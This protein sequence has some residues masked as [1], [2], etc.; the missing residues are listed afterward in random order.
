M[1]LINKSLSQVAKQL[2]EL[3]PQKT[4]NSY[5]AGRET[6]QM[7]AIFKINTPMKPLLV[8]YFKFSS[9]MNSKLAFKKYILLT[10]SHTLTR[11]SMII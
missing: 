11:C 4:V 2:Q 5:L 10:A 7:F 6:A 8:G 3:L 9:I 1:F